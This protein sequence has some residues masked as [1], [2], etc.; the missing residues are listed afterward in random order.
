[1]SAKPK[2]Q[3]SEEARLKAQETRLRKKAEREATKEVLKTEPDGTTYTLYKDTLPGTGWVIERSKGSYK[4]YW[5]TRK[6]A[7]DAFFG[8]L[9]G[10][11]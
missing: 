2:K 5:M 1:M 7:L 4:K 11:W 6:Q 10:G 9:E 3:F 8:Y